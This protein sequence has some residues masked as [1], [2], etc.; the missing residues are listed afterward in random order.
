MQRTARLSKWTF[1]VFVLSL[2]GQMLFNGPVLVGKATGNAVPSSTYWSNCVNLAREQAIRPQTPEP[3]ALDGCYQRLLAKFGMKLLS[4][5]STNPP[6]FFSGLLQMKKQNQQPSVVQWFI[7][8]G[9]TGYNAVQEKQELTSVDSDYVAKGKVDPKVVRGYNAVVDKPLFDQFVKQQLPTLGSQRLDQ[10]FTSAILALQASVKQACNV[11]PPTY[12]PSPRVIPPRDS[13]LTSDLTY[14]GGHVI[15]SI[16]NIYLIFWIDASYQTASPKYVNLIEQFVQDMG[17]S[18]LYANLV[19]YHDALGRCPTG[20]RLAG[21]FVDNQPFPQNL[22]ADHENASV[23]GD[24]LEAH[25]GEASKQEIADVAA[26]QGWDTKNYHNLFVSLPTMALGNGSIRG[27][28]GGGNHSVLPSGVNSQGRGDPSPYA[29][30][31][32]P[33]GKGDEGCALKESP[34]QDPVVDDTF[35]ALSHELSEAVS[36]PYPG[37]GWDSSGASGEMG[38]KCAFIP[39]DTIDPTTQGNVTWNG[40]SYAIQPEWDNLQHGCVWQGP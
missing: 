28:C 1:P 7:H 22:V 17:Q 18:P 19:Q 12:N 40:H 35:T 29:L 27:G 13:S 34:N 11:R 9:A 33:F 36:D 30:I 15:D 39:D 37:S 5:I 25:I 10:W 14:Q 20:A 21:T 4:D 38:D 31:L 32:Y 16:A 24:V 8:L 6:A 3:S 23:S 2:M 26:K